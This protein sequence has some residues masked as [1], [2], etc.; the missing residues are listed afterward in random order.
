MRFWRAKWI[1]ITAVHQLNSDDF[2]V[3]SAVDGELQG[4]IYR[5]FVKIGSYTNPSIS[6]FCRVRTIPDYIYITQYV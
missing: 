1:T 5:F 6:L 3:W 4:K 2:A